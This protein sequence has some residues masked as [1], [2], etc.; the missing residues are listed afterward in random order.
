[1]ANDSGLAQTAHDS[2]DG[3][4]EPGEAFH[5]VGHDEA[6]ERLAAAYRAGRLSHAVILAGP[7]GI[8]KA[9]L[10]FRMARYLAAHPDAADAP[11][12]LADPDPQ[13]PL[14]RQIARQAH[15]AVLHITRPANESGGFKT[16][17]TVDEIRRI[18]GFLSRSHDGGWRTVIIDPADD[19]NRNAANA[20]LKNLEEPPARTLFV[21]IAHQ[22]SRLLPTIRSRCQTMTLRALDDTEMLQALAPLPVTVPENVD[23][24]A[25]WLSQARGSV[26]M[27]ILLAEYGGN[28]ILQSIEAATA[29]QTLGLDVAHKLASALAAR[30]ADVG[31]TLYCDFLREGYAEAARRSAEQGHLHQAKQVADAH[32]VFAEALRDT[33]TYNLDRKQ[34]ILST[35]AAY[36]G[37]RQ[38]AERPLA[39]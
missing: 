7:R 5:L 31:F 15:P 18:G 39:G 3:I 1:M 30:G 21:I 16:R 27:A 6:A 28:D 36:H 13:S 2:L 8:G 38:T 24:R 9:T 25:A 35:L 19:M 17:I 14:Y 20:L 10:A 11:A 29:G 33:E 37:A 34:F 4:A 22:P 23:E 32:T 12:H 26:R